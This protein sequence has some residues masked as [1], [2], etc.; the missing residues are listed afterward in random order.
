LVVTD[1]VAFHRNRTSIRMVHCR[2]ADMN[3]AAG[4]ADAFAC[5][6]PA[7]AAAG[8]VWDAEKEDSL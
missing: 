6:E 5:A 1:A 4:A 2:H 3:E 7:F 8:V